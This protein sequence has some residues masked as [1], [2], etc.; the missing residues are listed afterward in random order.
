MTAVALPTPGLSPASDTSGTTTPRPTRPLCVASSASATASASTPASAMVPSGRPASSVSSVPS[1]RAVPSVPS[2]PSGWSERGPP[3]SWPAP[4][5]EV[6][7]VPSG[8]VSVSPAS[9]PSGNA[10]L[11]L[12]CPPPRPGSPGPGSPGPGSPGP[13]SPGPGSPG[14]GSPGPGS[15]GSR[16]S[17]IGNTSSETA[18]SAQSARS[19]RPSPRSSPA[20]TAPVPVGPSGPVMA[21]LRVRWCPRRSPGHR[22][23]RRRRGEWAP[24]R[25]H[26]P[27][28]SV[29]PHQAARTSAAPADRAMATA[30]VDMDRTVSCPFARTRTPCGLD[31]VTSTRKSPTVP[32]LHADVD[33]VGGVVEHAYRREARA[34]RRA[35]H[36]GRPALS[37]RRLGGRPRELELVAREPHHHRDRVRRVAHHGDGHAGRPCGE[38]DGVGAHRK[39]LQA[40]V[41]RRLEAGNG[42][43]LLARRQ[44]ARLRRQ[45]EVVEALGRRRS[46]RRARHRTG[47]SLLAPPRPPQGAHGQGGRRGGHR[48]A[49]AGLVVHTH[50]DL[51]EELVERHRL[52]H[53]VALEAPRAADTKAAWG[54]HSGGATAT[55]PRVQRCPR[56]PAGWGPR[57]R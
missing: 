27:R 5:T 35:A 10:P 17:S 29:R 6:S 21:R 49:G 30:E 38:S 16:S 19:A 20:P 57:S 40:R 46:R 37:P 32:R 44:G 56:C 54:A 28:H 3:R 2:V 55:T 12:P 47:E 22:R 42:P 24:R 18:A 13:G 23:P 53:G 43:L 34:P 7:P 48:P 39:Q 1:V 4:A 33:G 26:R 36:L 9:S 11:T 31:S 51:L 52:D 45:E 41:E 14:P 8:P 50:R 25:L 15:P